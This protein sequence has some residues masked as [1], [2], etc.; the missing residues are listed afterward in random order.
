MKF[1]NNLL[2]FRTTRKT[3]IHQIL[4]NYFWFLNAQK[5]IKKQLILAEIELH[6]FYLMLSFV[7][8]TFSVFN[9]L[10]NPLFFQKQTNILYKSHSNI[11][12][13]NLGTSLAI[14][15]PNHTSLLPLT[16]TVN[17]AV[18]YSLKENGSSKADLLFNYYSKNLYTLN[19]LPHTIQIFD[20]RS[21]P[22][23]KYTVKYLIDNNPI[24]KAFQ[25]KKPFLEYNFLQFKPFFTQAKKFQFLFISESKNEN[26]CE[27]SAQSEVFL[28]PSVN[29]N[30]IKKFQVIPFP[31]PTYLNTIFFDAGSQFK[32]SPSL[33]VNPKNFLTNLV[34]AFEFFYEN[35]SY[36]KYYSMHGLNEFYEKP[37][38]LTKHF[39]YF[40]SQP[41]ASEFEKISWNN[42]FSRIENSSLSHYLKRP[43]VYNYKTTLNASAIENYLYSSVHQFS[44][45]REPLGSNSYLI[46]F[47]VGFLIFFYR[48]FQNLYKDYGKEILSTFIDFIKIIGIID[49]EEWL[50]DDLN[51]IKQ[52][53]AFRSI[54]KLNTRLRNVAGIEHLILE[55]GEIIWLCRSAKQAT[56]GERF[57]NF[58]FL[59]RQLPHQ[60]IRQTFQD[61]RSNLFVNSKAFLFIGPPGTGKTLLVQAIAGESEVPILVQSGSI[62]KNPRQRGK[63]AR[64]IQKLF[65]RARQI[66]PCII[67][68]DEVDGIGARRAHLSLNIT[69][70]YDLLELIDSHS[71]PFFSGFEN[72]QPKAIETTDDL[73][74]FESLDML[75]DPQEKIS[76]QVLQENEFE[77]I[78]RIEQLSLLTQLL[79]ELDGLRPLNNIVVIGATN[80]FGILD[81]AL[82]RPGRFNNFLYLNL[83]NEFKRIDLFKLYSRRLGFED[84][85]LWSYFSKRTEGLSSADIAAIVNESAIQAISENKKHNIQSLE[86]GIDRITTTP[87]AQLHFSVEHESRTFLNDYNYFYWNFCELRKKS[88]KYASS[89]VIKNS[90]FGNFL[91][92]KNLQLQIQNAYYSIGKGVFSML[93]KNMPEVCVLSFFTR[94]P[95]FRHSL[96]NN[97]VNL[98]ETKF[99]SRIEVEKKL[100]YLLSGKAAELLSNGL[101]M[102][103]ERSWKPSMH[104]NLIYQFYEQSNFGSQDL[105]QATLLGKLMIHKWYFYAEQVITEKYHW[106]IRNSNQFE[107]DV[108]EIR[109]F[110]AIAEEMESQMDQQNIFFNR[111]Q[112]WSFRSWWQQSIQKKFNFVDRSVLNWYRIYLSDPEESEQNI[113]WV[114]PDDFYHTENLSQMNPYFFWNN[115]L[116]YT[117]DYIYH[118]LILNA[119]NLSFTTIKNFRELFDLFADSLMRYLKLQDQQFTVTLK[120]FLEFQKM[121]DSVQNF[122]KVHVP[123]SK[124]PNLQPET[125]YH[126]VVI[127]GWGKYSRR[128]HSKKLFLTKLKQISEKDSQ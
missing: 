117:Q 71:F 49:D 6:N 113:E 48:V 116:L 110:K 26:N 79:I 74:T 9:I 3:G 81:P 19:N 114:P 102:S 92:S 88:L 13:Q 95:N 106:I 107:L 122:E 21:E 118:S 42:L 33:A 103:T 16:K 12:L 5:V 99:I 96:A 111:A 73:E 1:F 54:K 80:R 40:C 27:K 59:K 35:S 24:D 75:A 85:I 90:G 41:S 55:I 7:L 77:N 20:E 124:S 17:L 97:L 52:Q 91:T 93:F 115:F 58:S 98:L 37:H 36:L 105:K 125:K 25:L 68:I 4:R 84:D 109:L 2:V 104:P 89:S 45:K 23:S 14:Q 11:F 10:L 123:V 60:K 53:K 39:H 22:F 121:A 94:K 87:S 38:S 63:G 126:T 15:S 34:N 18:Q 82:L 72:I 30:F 28:L 29:R 127:N 64:T 69:G 119:F 47:Q 67:F 43:N 51:L 65:Q 120:K 86:I 8:M 83:P 76:L 46:F 61:M 101:T 32:D 57:I 62:L 50:K 70:N 56:F 78:S 128:K 31:K 44:D 108:E 66:A 100:V 112:K